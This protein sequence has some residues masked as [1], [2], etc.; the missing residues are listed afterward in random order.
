M[1][2]NCCFQ[3]GCSNGATDILGSSIIDV[4]RNQFYGYG[5]MTNIKSLLLASA[6]AIVAISGAKAAD[7]IVDQEPVPVVAA[8]SFTWNGAYVGGQVGYGGASLNS[9]AASRLSLM[10]SLAVCML[11]IISISVT[12]S[13]SALMATSATTT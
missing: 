13:F 10:A 5:V 9:K 6:V 3:Q 7:T 1:A 4:T 2:L 8:P 11:V 12:M